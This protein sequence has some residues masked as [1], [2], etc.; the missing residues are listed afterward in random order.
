VRL[1]SLKV[2]PAL[3]KEGRWEKYAAGVE[4]RIASTG[5]P[6]FVAACY[7]AG[8]DEGNPIGPWPIKTIRAA[9]EF[10]LREWKGLDRDDDTPWPYSPDDAF[11]VL[12]DPA[13]Y[14]VLEFVMLRGRL[15]EAE[16]VSRKET[17]LGN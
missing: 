4:L 2:D 7:R 15:L 8:Q 16:L 11:E 6:D 9:S 5:N 3:A 14:P 10:V 13:Y 12:T 1:S 17:A